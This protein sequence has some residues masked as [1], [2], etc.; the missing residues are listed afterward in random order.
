MAEIAIGPLTPRAV[1]LMRPWSDLAMA[2]RLC[3]GLRLPAEIPLIISS[4][5]LSSPKA[6]FGEVCAGLLA[7][8]G[9]ARLVLAI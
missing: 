4:Y 7:V 1:C 6:Q 9:Y 8:F 3:K 5:S 2:P